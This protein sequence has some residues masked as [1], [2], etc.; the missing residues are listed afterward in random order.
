MVMALTFPMPLYFAK[1]FTDKRDKDV[2]SLPTFFKIRLARSTADSSR[3]PERNRMA[4]SSL[5]VSEP[6]PFSSSFSRGLS[7][8]DHDFIVF[9][10]SF[11]IM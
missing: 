10:G 2:R 9:P 7:L 6:W 3:L 4:S 1:S 11:S 8:S 5:S